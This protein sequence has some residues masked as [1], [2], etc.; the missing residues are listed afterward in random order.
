MMTDNRISVSLVLSDVPASSSSSVDTSDSISSVD[1][2][3]TQDQETIP[4]TT[5]VVTKRT[6]SI[7]HDDWVCHQAAM[8][9]HIDLEHGA[10]A[11]GTAVSSSL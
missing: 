10:D 1:G 5:T 3:Q 2:E 4:W 8:I 11:C 6:K 7:A 9:F